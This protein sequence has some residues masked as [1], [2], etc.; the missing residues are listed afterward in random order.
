LPRWTLL[1]AS[2]LDIANRVIGTGNSL[3]SVDLDGRIAGTVGK[4]G[5][6]VE[7]M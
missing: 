3:V 7:A 6:S 2:S 4:E 1:P 5:F